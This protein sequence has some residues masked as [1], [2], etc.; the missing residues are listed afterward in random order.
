MGMTAAA[1]LQERV[2]RLGGESGEISPGVEA[3][4]WECAGGKWGIQWEKGFL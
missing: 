3:G 1:F 2:C 4:W